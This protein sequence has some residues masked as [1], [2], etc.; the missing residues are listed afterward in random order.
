MIVIPTGSA[1]WQ[2]GYSA[3]LTSGDMDCPREVENPAEFHAGFREGHAAKCRLK[4]KLDE[5]AKRR[6]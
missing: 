1:S 5:A 4:R 2:A 3:G 6:R